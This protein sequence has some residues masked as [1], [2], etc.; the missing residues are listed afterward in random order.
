MAMGEATSKMT[1]DATSTHATSA[2]AALPCMRPREALARYVTGLRP[3]TAWS[4]PGMVER[5]TKMSLANVSGMRKM[6]LVVMTDSGVRTSMPTM[7]QSHDKAKENVSTSAMAS[8]TP[9]TPPP[10]RNPRIRPTRMMSPDAN[11]YRN[12]SPAS[13]P[14]NGDGC[15]IGS[16]RNRSYR[17]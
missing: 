3:T 13:A 11:E 1:A 6:K 10:G 9:T 8:S 4:Q 14:N 7:I 17:P 2:P 12:T 16:E 5:S 15:H